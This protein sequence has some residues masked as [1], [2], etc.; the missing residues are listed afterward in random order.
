[1]R[2]PTAIDQ[3]TDYQCA[4]SALYAHYKDFVELQENGEELVT[5]TAE[6]Y[7]LGYPVPPFQRELV[8]TEQQEVAFIESVW[9][10]LQIGTY[11]LHK[12]EWSHESKKERGISAK[13]FSGWLIDGQQRLNTIER[14]W[15]D[16]FKV[17]GLYWSELNQQE[18]IRFKNTKFPYHESSLWDEGKIRNLYN[19]MAFGGTNHKESERA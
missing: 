8:W 4:I 11:N 19:L 16:E 14:Y 5:D 10:G 18:V 12:M 7:V 3:G 2:I 13:K 9:L 6:R 1:M 15:N 17:F